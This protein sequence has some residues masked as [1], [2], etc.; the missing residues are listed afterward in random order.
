M[1]RT[2]GS[3]KIIVHR[4][5]VREATLEVKALA[6]LIFRCPGAQVRRPG[7]LGFSSRGRLSSH[8]SSL[9]SCCFALHLR[10]PRK[11]RTAACHRLLLRLIPRD[12]R[13][14]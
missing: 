6:L 5:H 11:E 2:H 3:F 14:Y 12:R 4:R 1:Q 13:R 10:I 9:L 8:L 7:P